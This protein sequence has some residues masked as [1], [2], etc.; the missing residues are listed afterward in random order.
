M[1]D[2]RVVAPDITDSVLSSGLQE[3]ETNLQTLPKVT[4]L[5]EGSYAKTSDFLGLGEGTR[6]LCSVPHHPSLGFNLNLLIFGLSEDRHSCRAGR[7]WREP[8]LASPFWSGINIF[9]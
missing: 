4:V 7:G 5:G 2:R 1:Y 9:L 6:V 8:A 3:T